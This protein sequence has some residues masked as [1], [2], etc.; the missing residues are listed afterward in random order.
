MH[1]NMW[2]VSQNIL[3]MVILGTWKSHVTRRDLHEAEEE[4]QVQP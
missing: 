4:L 3:N 1:N 2:N